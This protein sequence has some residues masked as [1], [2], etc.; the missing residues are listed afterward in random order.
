MF[1]TRFLLLATTASLLPAVAIAQDSVDPVVLDE[2]VFSGG[3]TPLSADGFTRSFTVL[4]ADEMQQRG[5]TTVQDA[6]RTIPGLAVT[7]TG[8]SYA[9]VRIRG[10]EFNHVLVLIDGIEANSPGGGDYIFSGLAL[11]DIE[12][13]EVLRGPQSSVH[14]AN[15]GAGVIS[16]TTR[17]AD[18]PG[19]SYGGHVEL[20]GLGTRAIG[21]NVHQRSDRGQISLSLDSR[22]VDGEDQSRSGGDKDFNDIDTINLKGSVN[23]TEDARAGFTLRRSWQEYG[24]DATADS[25]W[26]PVVVDDPADYLVDAPL[27]AD[28]N[29]TYGSLWLESDLLAGRLNNRLVLSGTNQGTDFLD[30]GIKTGDNAGKRRSLRY[31]GTY[32]LDGGDAAT[33]RQRM[34]FLAETER[35]EYRA[36]FA[37]G[38]TYERDR[39]GIA[40]EYQGSHNNGIDVQA[41]VR[42]DFNDVFKDATSWNL[43]AGWQVPGQDV[44]L[45]ASAGRAV[46]NPT[47]FEQFGYVPGSYEGNPDLKPEHSMNYE[48]GADIGF[49]EGRGQFRVALFQSDIDDM[50]TGTGTTSINVPGKSTRKGF[51]LG[52]EMQATDWLRFGADYTYIDATQATGAPIVRAPRH[53][54][55]LRAAADFAQGRGM[56]AADLRYVEGAYD[57]EW[58]TGSWTPPT[59]ELPSYTVVNLAAHY[60][61]NENVR[62]TGRVVNLFDEDYFEAWGYF[63]QRRTAYV[64]LQAKW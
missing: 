51:E 14:G 50:I 4:G 36:S 1:R 9:Q 52:A 11:D 61:L 31:T 21:A 26:P 23:L 57:M 2:I 54:L 32:A 8:D 40:I 39:H 63:G 53:S 55:G 60:D 25:F 59:T 41:G 15:A 58:F 22:R 10:S 20:G 38:G 47:M 56:V 7:A 49:A 13:I 12:R 44:R 6:L 64:G 34:V 17:S 18:Q 45:R 33:A 19:L 62:L 3:L 27:T 24:Y 48:I 35:E 30:D 29:E 5:V 16:I 46:V 43:S 37:P 42:R 28:R